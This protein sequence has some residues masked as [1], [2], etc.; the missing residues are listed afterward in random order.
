MIAKELILLLLVLSII[1]SGCLNSEEDKEQ[2]QDSS[3]SS[4]GSQRPKGAWTPAERETTEEKTSLETETAEEVGTPLETETS[5]ETGTSIETEVAEGVGMPEQ[6]VTSGIGQKSERG[7]AEVEGE[8][9]KGVEALR[10]GETTPTAHLVRL[11]D[12][13]L[14]P[15]RLQ[16][17]TGDLVVWRNF[18][19]SSLFTLTSKENLFKDQKLAYGNTLEQTFNKPGSYSFSVRGHPKM[20]MTITVK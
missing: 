8:D 5:G 10:P 14:I 11:N 16:V 2:K 6:K 3:D 7:Q 19:K 20:E 9:E 12:Y 1:F 17:N 15:L 18:Q 4:G 13:L